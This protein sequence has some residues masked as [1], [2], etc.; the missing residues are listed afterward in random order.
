MLGTCVSMLDFEQMALHKKK[1]RNDATTHFFHF[2]APAADRSLTLLYTLTP[3]LPVP[4]GLLLLNLLSGPAHKDGVGIR[5]T[6]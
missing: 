1:H 6:V 3:K 4:E 5:I 2:E